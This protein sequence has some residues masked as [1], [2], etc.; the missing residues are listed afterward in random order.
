MDLEHEK[1]QVL[2]LLDRERLTLNTVENVE[3]FSPAEILLKTALGRLKIC[4]ANLR[5]EDL[6][7]EGGSVLLI[8]KI[9]TLS[10]S[11]IKPKGSFFKDLLK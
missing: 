11:D 8:G 9:D 2:K 6:S 7:K 5:L 4:G 3:H 1:S 10:F